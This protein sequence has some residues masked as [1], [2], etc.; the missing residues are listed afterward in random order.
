MVQSDVHSF[1]D[2]G[3]FSNDFKF[4]TYSIPNDVF[5]GSVV[6]LSSFSDFDNCVSVALQLKGRIEN[7][8]A[9]GP[10]GRMLILILH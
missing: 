1:V 5:M 4:G 9:M 2:M 7:N 6:N 8:L 3:T 10:S